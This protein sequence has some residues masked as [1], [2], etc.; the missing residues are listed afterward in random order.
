MMSQNRHYFSE[1][2]LFCQWSPL[3]SKLLI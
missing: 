1:I 2:K 3:Y